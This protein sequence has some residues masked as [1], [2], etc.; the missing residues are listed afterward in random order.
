[1]KHPYIF[2]SVFASVVALV[3]TAVIFTTPTHQAE[4]ES[5]FR[6]SSSSLYFPTTG[7]IGWTYRDPSSTDVSADG[8]ETIHTG[9][10]I[11]ADGGTGSPVYAPA[12]GKVTRP[13]NAQSIDL[14]L[15][16]VTNILTGEKGIQVYYAHIN[17]SLSTGDTFKAGQVIGT[18]A[19]DHI[20][21]SV[22]AKMGYDDRVISQT[23][24][25]SPYYS[26]TLDQATS[27]SGR[28]E[29]SS[30]CNDGS[31]EY[32]PAS[33]TSTPEAKQ[34]AS[35][36]PT[37]EASA[38]P[39]P[40]TYTVQAGDTLSSIAANFGTDV[41]SIMAG[42]ALTDPNVLS[43]G[44][45]LTIP[46]ATGNTTAVAAESSEVA[47]DTAAAVPSEYTVVE[48]DTLSSIAAAFGTDVDS[49]MAANAL[50]DP[51]LL[52]IG[53]VLTIPGAA[54]STDAAIT[55]DATVTTDVATSAVGDYTV[56]EGDTLWTIAEANGT[57]V[58]ALMAANGLTED[59]LLSI[60]QVL[61]LP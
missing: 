47:E 12:D 18:Q 9:V 29:V 11:F 13:V 24:D 4:A 41:E 39:A 60:G 2:T 31:G 20:H 6:C 61:T 10:D 7:I 44:Q 21:F 15:P 50:T 5:A 52:S 19:S 36:A 25:P 51:S 23:Q 28:Q 34:T 48:G 8:S 30:W 56:V 22:G 17:P 32:A 37:P 16:G 1:L 42:N 43:I 57:D 14:D 27:M 59:S 54:A 3:V 55:T 53:Q 49:I 58:D 40:Q 38:T 26:A 33:A 46:G 35:P 45:E